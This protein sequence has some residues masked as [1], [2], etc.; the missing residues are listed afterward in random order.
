MNAN[1]VY[2]LLPMSGTGP[3]AALDGSVFTAPVDSYGFRDLVFVLATTNAVAWSA[4]NPR[5]QRSDDGLTWADVDPTELANPGLPGPLFGTSKA[6]V[7]VGAP[8]AA[9]TSTLFSFGTNAKARYFRATATVTGGGAGQIIA[10]LGSP[11]TEPI[12]QTAY[13]EDI[14]R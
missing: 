1:L 3:A 7:A 8:A 10:L 2:S 12:F 5:V 4:V 13:L 9:Q 11:E 6:A 14:D